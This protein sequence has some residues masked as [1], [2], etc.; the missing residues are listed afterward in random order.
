MQRDTTQPRLR[1]ARA[2]DTEAP[3]SP[4]GLR[5]LGALLC[6]GVAAIHIIDQGG[7]PGTKD[8]GYVQVLYYALEFGGVLTAVA[9]LA[10]RYRVRWM[11]ALSVAVGPIV[12]YILS[13]GPGLPNYTD[14]VGNWGETLGVIALAVETA[15]LLTAMTALGVI[16]RRERSYRHVMES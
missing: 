13:R 5:L 16:R 1:G 2:A 7:F 15:L 8:P 11:L 6:L 9:L 10:P 14:D 3:D 12:G 4:L